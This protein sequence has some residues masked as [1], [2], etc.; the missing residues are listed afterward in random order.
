MDKHVVVVSRTWPDTAIRID[1]TD[2]GIGISMSLVDFIAAL[3]TEAGNPTLLLTG[4][5]LKGRLDK[6]AAAV[7]DAMKA[8]TA[9][10]M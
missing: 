4:A 10:V 1:V 2:I 5:Q 8:E 6:A 3:A 7:C 9:K